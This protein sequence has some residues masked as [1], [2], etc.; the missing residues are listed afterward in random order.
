[1]PEGFSAFP[2]THWTAVV[3]EANSGDIERRRRAFDA[4][5]RDYWKP[6]Y[7]FARRLGHDSHEA[8]DLTQGFFAYLLQHATLGSATPELGRLRS[9][10]LKVF[11]RYI[12]DVRHRDSAQ[13][14]GGTAPIYSLNVDEGDEML[15]IEVAGEETPEMLYDRAWARALLR[16][17]LQDLGAME[18]AAGRGPLFEALKSQLNAET[19][20]EE[21]REQAAL[22]LGM[23]GDSIRQ[24]ISRL[25]KKFRDCLRQRIA[26][27]LQEP[28][29]S[30]IDE[31]LHALKAAL[32]Q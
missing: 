8:E 5:C 18:Q 2:T 28:S 23:S 15:V 19:E 16:G 25:R 1:M 17:T 11:Q 6:L 10:L 24:A 21:S 14:R 31:E 3:E 26:A 29:D 12:R 20:E 30:L 13:K 7:A 32:L 9:F 27:T 22:T 4:L